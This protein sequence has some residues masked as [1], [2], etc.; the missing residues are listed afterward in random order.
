[1]FDRRHNQ[2]NNNRPSDGCIY[3]PN[4]SSNARM[5]KLLGVLDVVHYFSDLYICII[6]D[7]MNQ[8]TII[9]P[10]MRQIVKNIESRFA[11]THIYKVLMH[12]IGLYCDFWFDVDYRHNSN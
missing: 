5:T 3:G 12:M 4:I 9:V 2:C 10:K 6:I 7:D 1:M 8:N 11:K